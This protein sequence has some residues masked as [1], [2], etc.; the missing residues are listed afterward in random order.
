MLPLIKAT[1]PGE[2]LE[3]RCYGRVR[4]LVD[5]GLKRGEKGHGKRKQYP[6]SMD[7]DEAFRRKV[8]N[9]ERIFCSSLP[10]S[11]PCMAM[12]MSSKLSPEPVGAPSPS[13]VTATSSSVASQKKAGTTTQVQ[14][15]SN[16]LPFAFQRYVARRKI[17][18]HIVGGAKEELTL[19]ISG[20]MQ[21]PQHTPGPKSKAGQKQKAAA[22]SKAKAAAA[23]DAEADGTAVATAAPVP[24]KEEMGGA[25]TGQL[26]PA[27]R[28]AEAATIDGLLHLSKQ[29][30]YHII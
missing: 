13:K 17:V 11:S 3:L 14:M 15:V 10:Y 30:G 28:K 18:P 25:G 23:A 20:H 26:T 27:K 22:A 6:D 5:P 21:Q 4:P 2:T 7:R 19:M 1:N 12:R 29:E 24:E 16:D 9:L 8:L